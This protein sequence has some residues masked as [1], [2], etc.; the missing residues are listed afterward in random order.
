LN[1][2]APRLGSDDGKSLQDQIGNH[3]IGQADRLLQTAA[4]APGQQQLRSLTELS[5]HG[6]D[7]P[8]DQRTQRLFRSLPD[9]TERV[10][11]EQTVAS[12]ALLRALSDIAGTVQ[13][14]RN[15]EIRAGND[16][17]AEM[18]TAG[19]DAV[20]G[21]GCADTDHANST[22]LERVCADDREPAVYA[23]LRG[24]R[25]CVAHATG[26]GARSYEL[27]LDL[28]FPGSCRAHDIGHAWTAD[29]A[30]QYS[31]G[32]SAGLENGFEERLR[33]PR[34]V[35]GGG[36]RLQGAPL[37]ARPLDTRVTDIDEKNHRAAS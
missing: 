22:A 1:V 25:V 8:L 36:L 11:R 29:V 2:S 31:V 7:S 20:D 26:G 12:A 10:V 4:R 13:Q 18:T 3:A 15:H 21:Q 14:A 27:R 24:L 35:H 34:C 6:L 17:P 33:R 5:S 28:P 23:E 37:E 30:D 16:E 19:I 9:C 32:E